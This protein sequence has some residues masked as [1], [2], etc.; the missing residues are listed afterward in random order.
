MN[1]DIK[2]VVIWGHKLYSHTHSF[3]HSGFFKA[4]KHLGYDTYWFD[5]N[6][7]IKDFDF[8]S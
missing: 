4:F 7:N 1:H 8:T 2:K 5:N 6:D 3:I